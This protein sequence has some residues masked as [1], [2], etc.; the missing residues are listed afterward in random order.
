MSPWT[1][2]APSA[3][4][5][6]AERSERARA[7][8]SQPSL[9]SRWIRRPPMK[10]EPPVTNAERA[11]SAMRRTLR[12]HPEADLLG[13]S[14][15]YRFD[16]QRVGAGRELPELERELVRAGLARSRQRRLHLCLAQHG[17]L[18]LR[19]RRELVADQRSLR[20]L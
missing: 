16:G 2:S 6:S 19:L 9:F 18:D 5:F 13:W 12:L 15:S 7:R 8:T 1:G 4:T 14:A 17:E 10:P 11:V 20:C 3:R